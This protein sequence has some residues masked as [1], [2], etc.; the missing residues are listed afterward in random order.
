MQAAKCLKIEVVSEYITLR[1][2]ALQSPKYRVKRRENVCFTCSGAV[3]IVSR[4][5]WIER[6]K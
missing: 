5:I 1:S 3:R 6:E 2:A 4:L